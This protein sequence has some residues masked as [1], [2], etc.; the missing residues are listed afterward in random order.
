MKTTSISGRNMIEILSVVSEVCPVKVKSWG[1][2]LF[3]KAH[4]FSEIRY[5]VVSLLQNSRHDPIPVDIRP[6]LYFCCNIGH[7]PAS[8][9]AKFCLLYI[10]PVSYNFPQHHAM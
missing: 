2:L 6:S 5:L 9:A 7:I 8:Y 4:L 10:H 3:K 1:A